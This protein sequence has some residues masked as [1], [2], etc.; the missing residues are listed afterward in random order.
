MSSAAAL[1]ALINEMFMA[2][3]GVLQRL[4]PDF[5][6]EAWGKM[7]IEKKPIL[8][9]YQHALS[10]LHKQKLDETSSPYREAWGLVELRNALFH[11]KPPW[12]PMT[13]RRIEIAEILADRF[14]VSP[15]VDTGADFV[16]KKCMSAGCAKWAVDTVIAFVREFDSRAR[17]DD[18]KFGAFTSVGT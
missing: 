5:K 17:L 4:I 13:K 6:T 18:K 11:Y 7:R 15:F 14:A 3:D 9:K 8:A 12:D 10:M 1:E 16:S 2:Q